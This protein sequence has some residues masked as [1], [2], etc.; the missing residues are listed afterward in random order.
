MELKLSPDLVEHIQAKVASGEFPDAETL[1]EQAVWNLEAARFEAE[2]EDWLREAI[3]EG[4]ASGEP[5]EV[6][7][8]ELRAR[9]KAGLPWRS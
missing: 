1:I 4:L 3:Q 9:L 5:V 2:N 6:D 8:E 7:L